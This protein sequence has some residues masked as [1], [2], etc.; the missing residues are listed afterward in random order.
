MR[1]IAPDAE[2]QAECSALGQLLERVGDKWT[3]MVI[4]ALSRGPLR[5]NM[6]MHTVGGISHRMLTLTVRGLERDGLVTRTA[7][8]SIPPRVEYE[9]T[10]LGE[11]LIG[12]LRALAAWGRKHRPVIEKAQATYDARAQE[13]IVQ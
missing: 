3:A 7:F 13:S 1:S 4:G 9:L 8:A 6:L 10:D 2:T 11:S 12:P 5:F